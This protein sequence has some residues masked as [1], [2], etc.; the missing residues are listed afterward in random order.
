MSAD[1]IGDRL[2]LGMTSLELARD[3]SV[4]AIDGECIT[5]NIGNAENS[6]GQVFA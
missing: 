4:Y 6:R 5:N 2:L 1:K 3:A